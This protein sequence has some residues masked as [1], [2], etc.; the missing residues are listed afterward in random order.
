MSR[1][2]VAIGVRTGEGGPEASARRLAT[3][4]RLRRSLALRRVGGLF[5]EEP[6]AD[7]SAGEATEKRDEICR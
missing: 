5:W 3:F 4:F 1:K 7:A 2:P 6:P